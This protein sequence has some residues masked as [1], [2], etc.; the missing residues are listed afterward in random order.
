MWQSNRSR[1]TGWHSPAVPPVSVGF[2]AGREH[3]RA[4][5]REV[6]QER[7]TRALQGNDVRRRCALDASGLAVDRF[8][9]IHGDLFFSTARRA[10]PPRGTM[11]TLRL[12]FAGRSPAW[13]QALS[14][15]SALSPQP[16]ALRRRDYDTG[17]ATSSSSNCAR[18]AGLR[19]ASSPYT[20]RHTSV[21]PRI[22]SQ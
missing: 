6:R 5:D 9:M 2:P 22:Q 13:P 21:Q 1:S 10:P 11:L 12:G 18:N 3:E 20:L 14:P 16:S 19:T 15:P 17:A 4:A 8:Q 7:R